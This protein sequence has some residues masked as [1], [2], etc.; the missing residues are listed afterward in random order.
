MILGIPKE[1]LEGE[2]RVA[3]V[4]S[5]VPL[6]QKQGCVVHLESGAGLSAGFTD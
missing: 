3:I 2:K 5:H 1:S 6:L 4:P